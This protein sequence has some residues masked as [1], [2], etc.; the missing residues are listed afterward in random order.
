[1]SRE[2]NRQ[3]QENLA[4]FT[5]NTYPGRGI[6]LGMNEWGDMALQ[7][8]FVMGRS[9]NSRNRVLVEEEDV[10]RTQAYDESKV[11]DPSL[12]IYN[13]MRCVD[14][15]RMCMAGDRLDIVSN[16][17]QTDT[18]SDGVEQDILP[19]ESLMTRDFEPDS[20]NNT[21]RI[22]GL[23]ITADNGLHYDFLSII[24][25]GPSGNESIHEFYDPE[26]LKPMQADGVGAAI[27]TYKGNGDPLQSYDREP[28]A[29]PLGSGVL[30]TAEIYWNS[31]DE[32]NRVALAVK[33]IHLATREITYC[34]VN[35]NQ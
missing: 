3:A 20:P 12:I 11:E 16:G 9:D 19:I 14:I 24:R 32:N 5:E 26:L 21:P 2:I 18:V 34:I 28:V 23:T 8:Y 6:V 17:D 10:V 30:D 13:A 7:V 29:L 33:G 4:V 35:A 1:V 25:K 22:T 15:G 27:H 31:L